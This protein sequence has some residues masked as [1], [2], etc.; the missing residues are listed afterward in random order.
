MVSFAFSGNNSLK[1]LSLLAFVGL[2]LCFTAEMKPACATTVGPGCDATFM[3]AIKRKAWMEAQREI[4]IAQSIIA[5][6]DTVFA[7]GCINHWYSNS[8]IGQFSGSAGVYS[9][10]SKVDTYITAAFRHT[11][12]GGHYSGNQETGN[13]GLMQTLWNAARCASSTIALDTAQ[14]RTLPEISSY[15]SG[16]YPIVCD[17]SGSWGSTG[18]TS[19]PLGMFYGAHVPNQSVG[20][21][22][23]DMNLFSSVTLPL[24]EAG[25]CSAG[26]PTGVSIS[27]G[28]SSSIDEI[29]CPNPGCASN[30][31][32]CVD[33]TTL[34]AN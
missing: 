24:S 4:M 6:P 16:A 2:S 5:K 20:A 28:A 8:G 27:T 18:S 26:I 34:V 22:F 29:I 33:G 11:L 21:T 17:V 10:S 25:S 3:T 23:N 7:L 12:G 1:F 14:L 19:T 32:T 15:N 30:G 13:C 31:T 9:L